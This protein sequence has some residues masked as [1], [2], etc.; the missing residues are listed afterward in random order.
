LPVSTR[1]AGSAAILSMILAV[2]WHFFDSSNRQLNPRAIVERL[3]S[4]ATKTSESDLWSPPPINQARTPADWLRLQDHN[5]A[6]EFFGLIKPN[7]HSFIARVYDPLL[8]V[9]NGAHGRDTSD[10]TT[11]LLESVRHFAQE[12]AFPAA[13]LVVFLIA[14]VTL[15]LNYFL[16]TG[17]PADTFEGEEDE[18]ALFSVKTL[19]TPQTLDVVRL[20]SCSK[21][22]LASISLDRST[23]LWI[24]ERSRGYANAILQTGTMQPRLWPIVGSALDDNGRLLALC[25]D[26]GQVGLW[27]FAANAFLFFPKIELRGQVPILFS[28][29]SMHSGTE[30]DKLSLVIVTPD[31]FLTT[32]EARSGE[33]QTKRICSSSIMSATMYTCT[34]AGN[35]LV[36]VSRPGEVYILPLIDGHEWT[37]EVVAGLDPGPPPGSNPSKIRF[38]YGASSLGLIFAIRTE[39]VEI[40]D[41]N[42]RALVYNMTVGHVKPSSFRVLH[43]PRRSCACGSPAVHTLTVAYAEQDTD[44]M[45]MQTFTLDETVGSQI[46]LGKATD[47]EVHNCPGL[48]KATEAVHCVEPA[49]VWEPTGALRIVGIRRCTQSPTPSS[50]ASGVDSGYF[51][52]EP[53]ALASALKQRA[54]A[55]GKPN[56]LLKSLDSAFHSRNPPASP[57]D[58][59]NW[60][61]WT[62]SSDGEFRA[63]PLV[64][65]PSDEADPLISE[66]QLFVAAPGPITRL[67]KRSVAVGFGNTVKVITWGKESF[68]GITSSVADGTLDLGVGSYRKLRRGTGRKMQ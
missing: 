23:S 2:N 21:G 57:R 68:D 53:S 8:V 1:F 45:L 55:E 3:M 5:T 22:H 7:A 30:H 59:D 11:S 65:D 61:A 25:S 42:S 54:A 62:L 32:I 37:A 56:S 51:A 24:N 12:H 40:F 14:G 49:G 39:E 35:N 34:K 13:L 66:E 31:G 20:S 64:S 60:E 63:R 17:L 28:F 48:S 52:A 46:C 26:N 15:L 47:N 33:H 67:G 50:T 10:K 36:Y 19:P 6:R 38:V 27:S 58:F 29:I 18:E 16:W 4:R 43:S 41:F 44:H 9:M